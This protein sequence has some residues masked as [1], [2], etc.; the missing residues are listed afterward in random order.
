MT[1]QLL[2]REFPSDHVPLL[3]WLIFTGVCAFGFVL[4][5]YYGLFHLMFSSDKTY[6]SATITALYVAATLHCFTRTIV[7]SRELDAAHRVA[8]LVSRGVRD[9]RVVGQNVVTDDGTRLPPGEVT[10]H[11]R[12]LILKAQLQEHH[13]LDQTL[14]SSARSPATR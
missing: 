9:F 14:L 13:R 11:I 5:W 6:I 4:I 1:V 7:I 8:A 2:E 12:N 3:R 10:N